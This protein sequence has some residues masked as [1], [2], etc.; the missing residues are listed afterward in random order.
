MGQTRCTPVSLCGKVSNNT[1][2][3]QPGCHLTLLVEIRGDRLEMQVWPRLPVNTFL[4][5]QKDVMMLSLILRSS[6]RDGSQDSC[7]VTVRMSS[8]S[9]SILQRSRGVGSC[10]AACRRLLSERVV[11]R[12]LQSFTTARH[13]NQSCWNRGTSHTQGRDRL[14]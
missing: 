10:T 11:I 1:N 9:V 7:Q 4:P 8:T 2:C 13:W 5:L 3:E 14:G 6:E 12:L